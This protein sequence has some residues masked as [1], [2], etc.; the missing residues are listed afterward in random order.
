MRIRSAGPRTHCSHKQRPSAVPS[1]GPSSR[2]SS[3]L[4]QRLS[5]RLPLKH[6]AQWPRRWSALPIGCP[7]R[8]RRATFSSCCPR[9]SSDPLPCHLY[10]S[11]SPLPATMPL[12]RPRF[13]PP[14]TPLATPPWS[15]AGLHPLRRPR[16]SAFPVPSPVSA[17]LS[18]PAVALFSVTVVTLAALVWYVDVSGDGG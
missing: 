18:M 14:A 8:D 11:P 12:F 9:L 5:G 4:S 7:G 17:P 15:P 1:S 2:L 6:V 10:R 3:L 16:N 13:L